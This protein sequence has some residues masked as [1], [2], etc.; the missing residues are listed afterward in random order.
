VV[1]GELCT[2]KVC[3]FRHDVIPDEMKVDKVPEQGR[4]PAG[5]L[6]AVLVDHREEDMDCSDD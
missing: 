6:H 5:C 2:H 4:A 1:R 3:M